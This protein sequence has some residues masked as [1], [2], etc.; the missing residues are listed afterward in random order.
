MKQRIKYLLEKRIYVFGAVLL[1]MLLYWSAP[2]RL[3]PNRR[4][5]FCSF[6]AAHLLYSLIGFPFDSMCV[7]LL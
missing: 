5:F 3:P 1:A 4:R 2:S 7:V 6:L